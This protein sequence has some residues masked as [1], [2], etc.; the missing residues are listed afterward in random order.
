MNSPVITGTENETIKEIAERMIDCQIGSVVIMSGYE[1]VGIVTDGNIVTKV[2][3][4]DMKPSEV[5]AKD[6]MSSP[7]LTIKDDKDVTEAARLMRKQGVKRLGVKDDGK[8][9]GIISI[10]DI[11]SVTPEIY[12]IV[13]EK[14]RMMAS[15]AMGR[16]AHLAGFCDSCNQWSDDLARTEGRFLCYDCRAEINIE[17]P[18]EGV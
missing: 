2:V 5:L 4:K 10:T 14:A 16:T 18:E 8:L 15:Q 1:P 7:L 13:A 11:V 12:A 3:A 9:M 6:I 17:T